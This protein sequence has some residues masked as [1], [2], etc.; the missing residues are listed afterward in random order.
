MFEFFGGLVGLLGIGRWYVGRTKEAAIY[1][2]VWFS[3]LL[4]SYIL[5]YFIPRMMAILFCLPL[6]LLIQITVP[7]WLAYRLKQE[8]A[9]Q[10]TKTNH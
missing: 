9:T 8:I 5:I 6:H 10:L 2:S 1:A 7:Y 3:W 4:L